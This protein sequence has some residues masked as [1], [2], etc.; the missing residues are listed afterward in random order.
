MRSLVFAVLLIIITGLIFATATDSDFGPGGRSNVTD[1]ITYIPAPPTTDCNISYTDIINV[2]ALDGRGRPVEGAVVRVTYQLDQTTGKGYFTT[3]PKLTGRDG[4]ISFTITN[5]ETKH[6]NLDCNVLVSLS[7]GGR[8]FSTIVT[9]QNHPSFID[10]FLDVY[11]LR[12][13][14]VDERN[15]AI[16]GAG[17]SINNINKTTDFG[18]ADFKVFA[19]INRVFVRYLDGKREAEVNVQNDTTLTVQLAFYRMSIFTTDEYDNPL[20][21]KITLDEKEYETDARGELKLEKVV[22]PLHTAFVDYGGRRKVIEMDLEK[23]EGYS[24]YFDIS[25]PKIQGITVLEEGNKLKIRIDVEDEGRFA[26]GV[27]SSDIVVRYATETGGTRKATVYQSG[28]GRY[29]AEVP[30][31]EGIT[32]LAFSISISDKDGNSVSAEG[33][34]KLS[35]AGTVPANQTQP[36]LQ[37]GSE[38]DSAQAAPSVIPDTGLPLH[39]IIG[40]III[41]VVVF[42]AVYRLKFKKEG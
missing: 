23:E 11:S 24:V 16:N 37:P 10:F 21:A 18:I 41:L 4:N 3:Q 34:H 32:E 25:P 5:R 39:Y 14:V 13:I 15:S 29:V 8:N 30:V 9:A 40:G 22:G 42:Y 28:S 7:A 19:G 6:E 26:S 33:V 38:N 31:G 1:E 27:S 2:R 20:K 35:Y 12:V 36:P 17:V